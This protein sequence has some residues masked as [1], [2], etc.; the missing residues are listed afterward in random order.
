ML[1]LCVY[2]DLYARDWL[3][4]SRMGIRTGSNR[5]IWFLDAVDVGFELDQV[6]SC[7][8]SQAALLNA[9]RLVAEDLDALLQVFPDFL[10]S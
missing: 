7:N 3:N 5:L 4:T 2:Y 10:E 6:K 1:S 9:R 8:G